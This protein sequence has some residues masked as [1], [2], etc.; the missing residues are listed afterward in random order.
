MKVLL[1]AAGLVA[2]LAMAGPA[3]AQLY[4]GASIGRAEFKEGCLGTGR[5]R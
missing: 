5:V 2:A 1:T 3:A 4:L